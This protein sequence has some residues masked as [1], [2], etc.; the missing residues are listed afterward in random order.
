[1]LCGRESQILGRDRQKSRVKTGLKTVIFP[2]KS[3]AIVPILPWQDRSAPFLHVLDPNS[4]AFYVKC[5][6]KCQKPCNFDIFKHFPK[7]TPLPI[8]NFGVNSKFDHI[9]LWLYY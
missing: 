4:L 7:F 9:T 5:L 1:M 8:L 3:G 6:A 2:G